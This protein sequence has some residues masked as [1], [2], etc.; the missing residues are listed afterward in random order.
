MKSEAVEGLNSQN[1]VR[2]RAAIHVSE[3]LKSRP[4]P[5]KCEPLVIHRIQSLQKVN[6]D[7]RFTLFVVEKQRIRCDLAH[8]SFPLKQPPF[9]RVCTDKRFEQKK[10]YIQEQFF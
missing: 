1:H 7:F 10:E 8:A 3:R 5:A 9:D 2:N 4:I 6:I